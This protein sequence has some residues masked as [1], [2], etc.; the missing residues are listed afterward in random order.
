MTRSIVWRSRAKTIGKTDWRIVFVRLTHIDGSEGRCVSYEWRRAAAT[1][2]GVTY[3]ADPI[4]RDME[5][6]PRYDHNNGQTAGLPKSL[7]KLHVANLG[8]VWAWVDD[9]IVPVED[10][11]TPPATGSLFDAIEAGT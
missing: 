4:W 5:D 7:A 1:I 11:D 6:H 2:I 10:P 8:K 9:G 3:D